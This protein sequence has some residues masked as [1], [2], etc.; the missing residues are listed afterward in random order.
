MSGEGESGGGGGCHWSH[1]TAL[2]ANLEQ[3][4]FSEWLPN[5][6]LDNFRTEVEAVVVHAL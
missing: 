5:E 1:M 3:V 4:L 2:M 6:R